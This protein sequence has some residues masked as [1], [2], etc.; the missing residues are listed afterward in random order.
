[1]ARTG[2]RVTARA[3]LTTRVKRCQPFEPVRVGTKVEY[4]YGQKRNV[5]GR[6]AQ[7]IRLGGHARFELSPGDVGALAGGWQGQT[8]LGASQE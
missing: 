8:A 7:S 4:I 5:L 3:R 2:N 6:M 1:M